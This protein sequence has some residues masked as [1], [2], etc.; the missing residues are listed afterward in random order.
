M[1][2]K[3]FPQ[4]S[5]TMPGRKRE[6]TAP[7]HPL[8][9]KKGNQENLNKEKTSSLFIRKQIQGVITPL[10]N[11]YIRTIK[12]DTQIQSQHSPLTLQ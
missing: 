8:L 12:N 6:K 4:N 5:Q 9:T 7:H 3:S 10:S 1:D 2:T 11:Y